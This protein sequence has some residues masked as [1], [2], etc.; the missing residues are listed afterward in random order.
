MLS[1][2]DAV[3]VGLFACVSLSAWHKRR[4]SASNLPLG[5]PRRWLLG[6]ILDMPRK[7]QW[8][9]FS[10]WKEQYGEQVLYCPQPHGMALKQNHTG[11]VVYLDVLGN[12]IL[13]LNSLEAI[14]DLFDKQ[15]LNYSD[16][17]TF[18]MVGELMGLDRVR[19]PSAARVFVQV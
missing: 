17:P 18:T 3:A 9:T 11:D 6:N 5:P 19:S 2:T 10:K 14:N 16:R 8:L 7:E 15:A 12:S 13:V 1:T 4:Q